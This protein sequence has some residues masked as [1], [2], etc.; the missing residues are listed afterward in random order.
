M[1][2]RLTGDGGSETEQRGKLDHSALS[3]QA[4]VYSMWSLGIGIALQIEAQGHYI[5]PFPKDA[6]LFV[7]HYLDWRW[8]A[9]VSETPTWPPPVGIALTPQAKRPLWAF[10]QP[11]Y[12]SPNCPFGGWR[13]NHGVGL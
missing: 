6:T 4:L 13:S 8:E 3:T 7:I 5:L 1:C 9:A 2:R 12:V 11:M 10:H